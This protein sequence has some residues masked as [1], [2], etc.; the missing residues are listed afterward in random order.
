MNSGY[1]LLSVINKN[2]FFIKRTY[3]AKKEFSY[4]YI[5]YRVF[6][7][8]LKLYYKGFRILKRNSPWLSPASII[9][10][11]RYLTASMTFLEYGSGKSTLFF[12]ERVKSI[13]SV[14][15][16]EMWYNKIKNKFD[17]SGDNN[18]NYALIK[19]IMEEQKIDNEVRN[20]QTFRYELEN[21]LNYYENI[22]Q[23]PDEYFDFILIDGRA[24]VEC[25][26]RAVGKLKKGGIFMLD[27]SERMRYRPVHKMLKDWPKINTTTG[28]TDTTLW[29]K[30]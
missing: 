22:N 13:E 19:P 17:K 5:R 10:M 8:I 2:P 7:P 15:H 12:S 9:F 20:A 6:R 11:E 25:S 16:N 18:I 21:Y 14:E 30:P 27:N 3:L 24:R 1:Q 28:L 26:R 29:F 23:Y 4:K